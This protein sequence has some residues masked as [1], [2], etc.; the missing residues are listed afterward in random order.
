MEVTQLTDAGNIDDFFEVS[1]EKQEIEFYDLQKVGEFYKERNFEPVW[2]HKEL[3]DDLYRNIENIEEE[4][5]FFEDYHGE[6]IQALYN[7]LDTNTE[8]ENNQLEILLTDAFLRLSEDLATGKLNPKEIYEIWGSP[9]NEINSIEILNSA[10]SERDISKALN[11]QK[12]DHIVYKGLKKALAEYKRTDWRNIEET[13]I[14][15]GK[16]IRPGEDDERIPAI[17]KRLSELGYYSQRIDSLNFNYNKDIQEALKD[18]QKAHDLQVDGLLGNTTVKNLNYTKE[19]RLHQ[20]LVNLERWRWHPGDLGEHY[21]I[22]NIP[23]Y[24]LSVVKNGDTIRTH[25]TVVGT[26]HRKTPVFS[27][28]IDYIIYNPTWTIPPTIRKRDVI[29]GVLRDKE[30]LSKKNIE[31]FDRNGDMVDPSTIDWNSNEPKLYT[32]RQPAGVTNPL[33]TV[34]IIYPNKYMI[35]LHDTPSKNLFKN[36]ARAQ[37]SGCVRVEDAQSLAKYLLNDQEI[38][39]DEKIEEILHSGETTEISVKQRVRVH[40]F[41][42]TAYQK[43]DTT[44]FIDDIYDLDQEL[45]AL[46]S[47]ET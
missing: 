21:I 40:H 5:L 12:P 42:W 47:P 38:Y 31:I 16:L 11:S 35:Y 45:W 30:Y 34:K 3:R 41:Y 8:E 46:L 36:N 13:R 10:I 26:R 39:D 17:T 19:D 6:K 32:Y 28:E 25:K 15:E 20:I 22:I 14:S 37:S 27:D 9:L 43:K 44:K 18:F 24:Q 1:P 7:S 23:N 33:G 4:G 2:N 29:P